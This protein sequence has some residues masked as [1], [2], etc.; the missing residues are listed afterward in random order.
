MKLYF[1]YSLILV[2]AYMGIKTKKG[3]HILQQNFYNENQ[4]FLRWIIKNPYKVFFEPDMFF[5]MFIV[6]LFINPIILMILFSL[7]YLLALY[8]HY[9]KYK[10]EQTK[11]PLVITP[12]MKRLSVTTLILYLIPIAGMYH[13]FDE[14]YLAYYYLFIGLL[15]YLNYFMVMVANVVNRPIEKMVFYKYWFQASRKLK[16]MNNLVVV[17]VTG[18]Y[19]KTNTKN[20]INDILSIKYNS[21]QTPKNFNTTYGLINTINNYI[22]KFAEIFVAE[23][24]A[25]RVGEITR[26]CK[27]IKPKYAVLTKIG[28]AH[29]ETFGSQ[30]NIQKAKF[31]LVESIPQDGVAVLNGDDELQLNYKLKN[32]CKVVW[33]GID[34][35]DVDVRAENIKLSHKGMNFDCV[36]KGDNKKYPITTRLLGYHNVYNI[37]AGIAIG[38]ELGLTMEQIQLG[39]KKIKAYEHRLELK[40]YGKIN[41]IDDAYNSNPIGSKM[42]VEVLGLMPGKKIIVTPGMIDLG[43]KQFEMNFKFGQYIAEV[44][45]EVILI[46]AEQTKPIYEGLMSRDY[47]EKQIHILND[48]KE[49]FP[50]IEKLQ[51]KET[52]VLLENDLP[53]IFNEK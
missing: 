43:E 30:E 4:R 22:D 29:L 27:F 19:G 51:G 3:F 47:K 33:I 40:K 11:K 1:I 16:E 13:F 24:S 20:A 39:V 23:I 2:F 31:E 10:N 37:L 6:G 32:K 28:V 9:Q 36:L 48:V 41:I 46:G 34:N 35:K 44:C 15:I 42:A 50:L 12:R 25:M 53:D 26:S 5:I 45:D 38:L 14:A 52:Y 49:A 18:S 7:Y 8:F 21:F 17:G